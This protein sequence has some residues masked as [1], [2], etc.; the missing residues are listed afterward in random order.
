MTSFIL[1]FLSLVVFTS[2]SAL[3]FAPSS[4]T[5][6]RLHS[7][8]QE[9]SQLWSLS[10]QEQEQEVGNVCLSDNDP[11]IRIKE[12]KHKQWNLKYRYKA[13]SPGNESKPPIICIHPVGVGLSS[14]FWTKLMKEYGEKEGG[15][16]PI[17]AVD[18]IGCGLENGSDKWDPQEKGLFF[19]LSWVEGVETLIQSIVLPNYY[20]MNKKNRDGI[21]NLFDG[22]SNQEVEGCTV[23]VQGGLASVGVLLSSRNPKT[24]VSKLILT[25]PPTYEDM[26]TPVPQKELESNY[27]FLT[28]KIWGNLAFAVL[29]SRFAINLFSNLFLFAEECDEDWLDYTME[30]A[31]YKEAR[32]PVQ[33]FNAGLLSH[34]SFE[35]EM[36]TM[37]QSVLVVCGEGDKRTSERQMYSTNM[38]NCKIK[39]IGG[40]NVVPWENA[41]G[42]VDLINEFTNG[43]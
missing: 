13:P 12:Y 16:P 39:V 3:A 9:N 38:K 31:R 42:T 10:P 2:S 21:F 22:K 41:S 11:S 35:E 14:W 27:N 23:I 18:L 43:I 15:N 19:P 33:A 4:L 30:G 34:R 25:S 26:V 24:V 1:G 5:S 28:S 29:E 20:D 6:L 7:D 40:V 17:Y 8:L 32:T 37:E 36:T